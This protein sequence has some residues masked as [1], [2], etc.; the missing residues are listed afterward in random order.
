MKYRK[1]AHCIYYTR[2]HLVF[3]TRYR[4]K[5]LKQGMGAYIQGILLR[6]FNDRH[7]EIKIIEVKTD[8]DHI[9][10]LCSIPPKFSISYAV[11]LMKGY[12]AHAMRKQFNYLNNVY[13]GTDGR[14]LSLHCRRRRRNYTKIH[15]I[16][17]YCR[18]RPSHT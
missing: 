13:Y 11:R 1:G 18:S 16:P 15:T 12:S 8:I 6:S 4:R 17:G 9:H 10:V 2:Y 5:I 3:S 14:L 7:P